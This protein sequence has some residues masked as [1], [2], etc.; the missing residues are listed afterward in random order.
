M[1]TNLI[2]VHYEFHFVFLDSEEF[3]VLRWE[4]PWSTNSSFS[5]N[6]VSQFNTGPMFMHGVYFNLKLLLWKAF[7]QISVFYL[8]IQ[9]CKYNNFH[10]IAGAWKGSNI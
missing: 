2:V 8:C 4:F 7:A 1:I 6:L 3:N 9:F 5:K 10:F